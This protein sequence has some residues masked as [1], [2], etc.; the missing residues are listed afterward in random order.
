MSSSSRQ[1]ARHRGHMKLDNSP[2]FDVAVLQHISIAKNEPSADS[3]K[4]PAPYR[5]NIISH[6]GA[7]SLE[8]EAG[9]NPIKNLDGYP[10]SPIMQDS[11]LAL[12]TVLVPSW[13]ESGKE[14]LSLLLTVMMPEGCRVG[15]TTNDLT[16]RSG[17]LAER[18]IRSIRRK[19]VP[20]PNLGFKPVS[21][22]AD[23]RT[24]GQLESKGEGKNRCSLIAEHLR[25]IIALPS[26]SGG[27]FTCQQKELNVNSTLPEV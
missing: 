10:S 14:S 1:S 12:T 3:P 23:T 19:D 6:D 13:S 15:V 4:S 8:S 24:T 18:D 25:G 11:C 16:A 2:A 20:S 7:A 5:C 27:D 26:N 17:L 21:K 9:R 22:A